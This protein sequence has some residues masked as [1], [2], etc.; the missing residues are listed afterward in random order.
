MT[1][2]ALFGICLLLGAFLRV[3]YFLQ[4]LL[5][6]RTALRGVTITLD[7][8]WCAVAATS[9]FLVSL[10]FA[11]GGFYFYMLCGSLAG[12]FLVAVWL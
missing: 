10:F 2:I 1:Q 11:G 12:F 6:K 4:T 3:L 7:F 8:L 9:F 5:A